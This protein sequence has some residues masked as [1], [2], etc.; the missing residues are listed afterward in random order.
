ML[1][2]NQDIL[3]NSLT[4]M[5]NTNRDYIDQEITRLSSVQYRSA[6]QKNGTGNFGA[7]QMTAYIDDNYATIGTSMSSTIVS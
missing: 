3:K 5:F 1:G 2:S 6:E 7:R 4:K